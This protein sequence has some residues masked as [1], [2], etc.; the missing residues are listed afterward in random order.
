MIVFSILLLSMFITIALIPILR[1][2]AVRLSCIDE[3]CE[4]KVH[5]SPVPKVGGIA[6]AVGALAPV[7]LS[8]GADRAVLSILIGTGVIAIFGFM[9]DMKEFGYR[10]KFA[11]QL[12]AALVVIFFGGVKICFIGTLLPDG[13]LLSDWVAVPLTLVV[14]I[15][16]TNAV[17]L[18]DGLDGLAGG[19]M[20]LC[21]LCIG[22]LAY[23]GEH[24]VMTL[25]AVATAG[26][27]FGFLR[28]NTHPATIFMG[29]AGS[30][31][32][33]FLAITM[34][35]VITQ[36]SSVYSPLFPLLLLGLPVLDTLMVMA[37]RIHH[38]KSPFVAD[39]NHLH[40]KLLRLGLFHTEAVFIL[41]VFQAALVTAAYFLRFH[42]E[43]VLLLVYVLFAG[44]VLVFFYAAE[45]NDWRLE[46]PGTLDRVIKDRLKIHIREGA[47]VIKL[48][49]SAVEIAFPLLMIATCSLPAEIPL[50]IGLA[51]GG[52]SLTLLGSCL[53]AP[54][55]VGIFLRAVV[56]FVLPV[57]IYYGEVYRVGWLPAQ[58]VRWF[59]LSFG[60][61]I[62][63]AV[64]VL[65]FTRRRGGFTVSPLDFIILFVAVVIPNL[66][67]AAISAYHAGPL[68]AKIVVF[69]F[70]F[71]V[72]AGELRGELNRLGFATLVAMA[73]VAAKGIL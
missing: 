34:A 59:N 11:G 24:A 50:I 20:L 64:M 6:M 48:S 29:D 13:M 37:E 68:A 32:L 2:Y 33:G 10:T 54:K 58:L 45:K 63:F 4:R 47:V 41:Y 35:V 69:F 7:A 40:H 30:Q 55:R 19:L 22:F 72:L 49:Q 52:L 26:A 62:F 60:V 31:M 43:W 1:R 42:S 12:A 16:V 8:A 27:I 9:D 21:F 25:L 53:F 18:A 38:G 17:N 65:K 23:R 36:G 66:P 5:I 46:R 61:L 67:D 15:G 73:V 56:Y 39:K 28:F 14:F 57:V 51:A 71:E 70:V 3:P 44:S